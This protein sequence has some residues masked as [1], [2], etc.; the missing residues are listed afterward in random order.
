MT[1]PMSDT[2]NTLEAVAA[3]LAA[4][5]ESGDAEAMSAALA[6]VADADGLPLLAAAAGLPPTNRHSWTAP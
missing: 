6:K 5:F 3:C 4:A 2:L 1:E